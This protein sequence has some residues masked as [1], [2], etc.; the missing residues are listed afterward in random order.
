ML[1]GIL[2]KDEVHSMTSYHIVV[3]RQKHGESLLQVVQWVDRF[4][5]FGQFH[6]NLFRLVS[7]RLRCVAHKINKVMVLLYVIYILFSQ[8]ASD[9]EDELFLKPILVCLDSEPLL[10]A[11]ELK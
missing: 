3:L 6:V 1:D 11:V 5:D 2:E 4:V 9:M 8:V 10:K 7:S